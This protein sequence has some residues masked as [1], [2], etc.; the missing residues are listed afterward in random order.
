MKHPR[1]ISKEKG[2]STYFTGKPCKQGHIAERRTVNGQCC[3]CN[4]IACVQYYQKNTQYFREHKAKWSAK[5]KQYTKNYTKMRLFMYPEKNRFYVGLRNQR[6]KRATPAWLSESQIGEMK[7]LYLHARD[8]EIV[9]GEKYHVDHI[10][11]IKG[12]NVCGLHVPWNLQILPSDVNLSKGNNM[13]R[14]GN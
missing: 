4:K 5:N 3:E 13:P 9:T 12:R 11:P 2:L 7:N 6:Q 14:K 10:V 1:A 8:C